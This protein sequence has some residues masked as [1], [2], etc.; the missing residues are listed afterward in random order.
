[1][2]SHFL[3]SVCIVMHLDVLHAKTSN[4]CYSWKHFLWIVFTEQ[5]YLRKWPDQSITCWRLCVMWMLALCKNMHSFLSRKYIPLDGMLRP[6]ADS[7]LFSQREL[8]TVSP[9]ALHICENETCLLILQLSLR[10]DCWSA[11]PSPPLLSS[12]L[13]SSASTGTG[14]GNLSV[15]SSRL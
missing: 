1:M 6:G 2:R 11:L 5:V 7:S 3:P 10:P 12:P 14:T 13:L 9:D 4:H 15:L 8:L